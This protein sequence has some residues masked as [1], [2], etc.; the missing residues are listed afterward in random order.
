MKE[1]CQLIEKKDSEEIGV[2]YIDGKIRNDGDIAPPINVM[3]ILVCA[4]QI[5]A[6][7]FISQKQ[8]SWAFQLGK[9]LKSMILVLEYLGDR[10]FRKY[11][12]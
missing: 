8:Y 5:N 3:Y 4:I 7:T 6:S 2:L 10:N 12:E 9:N 1:L 11:G